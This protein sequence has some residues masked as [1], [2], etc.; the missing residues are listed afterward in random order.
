MEVLSQRRA[1]LAVLTALFQMAA[2]FA[3]YALVIPFLTE[4]AQMSGDAAIAALFIFGIG[5][6]IGN[7]LA[8]VSRRAVPTG[9]YA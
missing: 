6:V 4:F 7:L 1:R 5:G 3:T 9:P 2:Q 8:G